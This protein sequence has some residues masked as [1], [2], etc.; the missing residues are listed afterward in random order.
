MTERPVV[1][2]ID[3]EAGR[4]AEALADLP[5]VLRPYAAPTPP[6][7]AALTTVAYAL[8]APDRLAASRPALPALRWALRTWAGVNPLLPLLP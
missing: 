6:D 4:F 2:L 8:A 7:E 1:A 5:V 3:A